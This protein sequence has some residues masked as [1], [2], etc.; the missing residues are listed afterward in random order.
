MLERLEAAKTSLERALERWME[1][2][3]QNPTPDRG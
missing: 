2:E 3:E 1:L